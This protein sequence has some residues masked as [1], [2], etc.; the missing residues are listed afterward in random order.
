MAAKKGSRSSKRAAARKTRS[1]KKTSHR[2][3]A[4]SDTSRDSREHS[5]RVIVSESGKQP[6]SFGRG[7]LRV[8]EGGVDA[9]LRR[10]ST[11]KIPVMVK[12]PNGTLIGVPAVRKG[13]VT[14]VRESS[15]SKRGDRSPR[16]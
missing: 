9:A 10:L 11:R 13:V 6:S 12:T 7:A 2:P 16:R 5:V 4:R 15:N 1:A 8:F 3:K 14:I